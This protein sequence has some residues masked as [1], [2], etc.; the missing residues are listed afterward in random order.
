MKMT[1][2]STRTI[3]KFLEGKGKGTQGSSEEAW[4]YNTHLHPEVMVKHV[5]RKVVEKQLLSFSIYKMKHSIMHW[6][7]TQQGENTKLGNANT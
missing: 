1:M 3:A 4:L 5:S 6:H 7:H 2:F